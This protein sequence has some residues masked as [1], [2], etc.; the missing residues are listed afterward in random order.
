VPLLSIDS[1]SDPL[2]PAGIDP[3]EILNVV[4]APTCVA[5]TVNN[6]ANTKFFII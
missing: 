2:P 4:C 5:K 3:L 6:A 1:E